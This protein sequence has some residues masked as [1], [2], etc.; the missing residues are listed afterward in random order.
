MSSSHFRF[1]SLF[2]PLKSDPCRLS[3]S[4]DRS[5]GVHRRHSLLFSLFCCS[6]LRCLLLV[7]ADSRQSFL[8]STSGWK[9]FRSIYLRRGLAVDESDLSRL[10][11][12][13]AVHHGCGLFQ[14]FEI[15][16]RREEQ[17]S[18]DSLVGRLNRRILFGSRCQLANIHHGD[19]R[20]Q[21]SDRNRIHGT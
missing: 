1:T 4:L 14:S 13:F 18:N 5:T 6:V 15:P 19:Q 7:R 11:W 16:I 3:V 20:D 9:S 2:P 17:S 21:W 12:L 10:E 8:S